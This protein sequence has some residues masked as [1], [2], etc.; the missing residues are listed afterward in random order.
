MGADDVHLLPEPG[1]GEHLTEIDH[2]VEGDLHFVGRRR[3]RR[4]R[5]DDHVRIR[6]FDCIIRC[7]QQVDVVRSRGDPATVFYG[8]ILLVPDLN[9]VKFATVALNHRAHELAETREVGT[10]GQ[11]TLTVIGSPSGRLCH[12]EEDLDILRGG[13]LDDRVKFAPRNRAV[14]SHMI[15]PRHLLANPGWTTGEVIGLKGILD[16][17]QHAVAIDIIATD[18]RAVDE[19]FGQRILRFAAL[20]RLS[21]NLILVVLGILCAQA[22]QQHAEVSTL[23]WLE[24][25]AI[26]LEVLHPV[27]FAGISIALLKRLRDWEAEHC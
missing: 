5:H 9:S 15:F 14:R 12:A 27:G 26:S 16:Q 1:N 24:F 7:R 20:K 23:L 21:V 3:S 4:A 25:E 13:G 22:S 8:V 10:I 11:T 2:I 18:V 19:R 6:R 17:G